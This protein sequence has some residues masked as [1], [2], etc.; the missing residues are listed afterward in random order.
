MTNQGSY[1]IVLKDRHGNHISSPSVA[2]GNI[3][4]TPPV[5]TSKSSSTSSKVVDDVQEAL[6]EYSERKQALSPNVQNNVVNN[7]ETNAQTNGNADENPNQ[8]SE[9]YERVV[10]ETVQVIQ[11]QN[12]ERIR[13]S[14]DLGM[15]LSGKHLVKATRPQGS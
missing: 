14:T 2:S 6:R 8:N 7:K 15:D 11:N 5:T 1:D 4:I 3:V 12:K 13:T 10:R 9:E